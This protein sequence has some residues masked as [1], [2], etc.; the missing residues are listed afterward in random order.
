MY[1]GTWR[2]SQCAVKMIQRLPFIQVLDEDIRI[3]RREALLMCVHAPACVCVCACVSMS[4][5]LG[6]PLPVTRSHVV[7]LLVRV[8]ALRC[9]QVFVE[10][11]Q[12]F[13]HPWNRV[14]ER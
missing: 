4:S 12:H 9:C 1:H 3:N 13:A 10:A 7:R 11:P 2:Q 6:A 8:S 14:P 5:I